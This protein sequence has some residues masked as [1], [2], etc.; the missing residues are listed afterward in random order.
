MKNIKKP[1]LNAPRF[2][3]CVKGT[4]NKSFIESLKENVF[5]SRVLGDEKIKEIIKTFNKN[6]YESTINNRDGVE[7]PSQIGHLFIGTCAK[8]K[9]L[10][11]IDFKKSEEHG[12]I[13]NHQNW[14][15]DNH[16]AKIFFTTYSSK[17]KFKNHEL[18]CFNP[19]RDF[20]RA[21]AKTYGDNWKKYIQ[22]NPKIKI[23]TMFRKAPSLDFK[24]QEVDDLNSYNEFEF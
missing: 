18:W 8:S 20:K 23:S 11:N 24:K 5:G 17:Y 22:I 4:L 6:L 21:V 3:E 13:V 1:D 14:D 10:K 16:L 19:S 15:S 7:I 12:I 2:R 9:T